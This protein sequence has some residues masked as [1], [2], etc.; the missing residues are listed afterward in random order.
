MLNKK[1]TIFLE[2]YRVECNPVLYCTMYIDYWN[3]YC[4]HKHTLL[5]KWN[6]IECMEIVV[7]YLKYG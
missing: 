3:R 6:V 4:R 5:Y 1:D 2:A 7:V